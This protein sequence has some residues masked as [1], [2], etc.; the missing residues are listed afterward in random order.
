M[1]KII[2]TLALSMCV[3]FQSVSCIEDKNKSVT[4]TANAFLSAYLAMDWDAACNFCTDSCSGWITSMTDITD[5][6][7]S[8]I[9]EMKKASAETF[10]KIVSVVINEEGTEADV[11]YSIEAP[12]LTFPLEK[13]LLI[14]IEGGTALVDTVE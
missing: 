5:I 6:P 2:L 8:I 9:Q 3:V 1:K 14:K 10:F 11:A 12:G 13:H 7:E 4:E